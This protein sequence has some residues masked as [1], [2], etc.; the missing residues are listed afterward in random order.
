MLVI[1]LLILGI[2]GFYITFGYYNA[3][4][5]Q[6]NRQYDKL[7]SIVSS[8]A[9]VMDG[10]AVERMMQKYPAKDGI[11]FVEQDSTYAMYNELFSKVAKI[12][13][14][15]QPIYTLTYDK[16]REI[17]LQGIRSG[18][19]VY[20]RHEY[21]R[22][23]K[24]LVKKMEVGGT[25]PMYS[26]ENGVWLSA[27]HPVRNSS[28]ELICILEADIEFS[29]FMAMV[30]KDFME[31]ILITSIIIAGLAFI[32]SIYAR[33]ILRKD[34]EQKKLLIHQKNQIEVKN[35][36]IN[37]S[38]R[39][40]LNIQEALLPPTPRFSENFN[41]HFIVYLPKDIVSGD[42]YGLEESG[43]EVFFALGDCTGHGVPGAMVS[44]VCSNAMNRIMT[45]GEFNSTGSFLDQ[46]D[47]L[48]SD[49]FTKGYDGMDIALCKLNK[50][51]LTLEFSGANNGILVLSTNGLL[52]VPST[53]QPIG[54][55]AKKDVFRVNELQLNQGDV[56]FLF[57]D[58][59]ADQFGG[60]RGKKMGIQRFKEILLNTKGKSMSEVKK[61]LEMYFFEWRGT[62]EQVDDVSVIGI[63]I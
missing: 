9:L 51:N 61:D 56:I 38:I 30:R 55:H 4:E 7:K 32:L 19:N 62:C 57:S 42:F 36:E 35:R 60:S 53:R 1:Y 59:Y 18:E 58:G 49:K 23:P 15:E 25:L 21:V 47:Q 3:L 10:D 29:K 34:Q 37:D 24:E 44:V 16:H 41:D 28:G 13:H 43:N 63:Q 45:L 27:F 22:F 33:K 12:N 46:V 40:A 20:F 52:K 31:A 48:V 54:R 5:L 6:E 11:Q 39:Y 2:S 8:L 26:S 17:F 14:L 50:T